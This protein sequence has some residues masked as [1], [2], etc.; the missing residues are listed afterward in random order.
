MWSASPTG[1]RAGQAKAMNLLALGRPNAPFSQRRWEVPSVTVLSSPKAHMAGSWCWR[2]AVSSG[3]KREMMMEGWAQE[4]RRD[5]DPWPAAWPLS[6]QLTLGHGETLWTCER[7]GA[8]A[9]AGGPS[10]SRGAPRDSHLPGSPEPPGFRG[11]HEVSN[12]C[13]A[14]LAQDATGQPPLRPQLPWQH[15]REDSSPHPALAV[16]VR[17]G[18]H[19]PAASNL[20]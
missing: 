4:V 20:G 5:G 10:T 17:S 12:N 7:P 1:Q 2:V 9:Q 3:C 6:R 15:R 18:L 8:P 16:G 13:R 11:S 19:C 14:L